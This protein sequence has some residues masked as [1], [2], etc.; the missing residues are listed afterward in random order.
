MND[1]RDNTRRDAGRFRA[2]FARLLGWAMLV[3]VLT[4]GVLAVWVRFGG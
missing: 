4:A 3:V 1:R 2:R